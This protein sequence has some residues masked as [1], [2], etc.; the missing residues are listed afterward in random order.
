M[1]KVTIVTCAIVL[2]SLMCWNTF[3]ALPIDHSP[4]WANIIRMASVIVFDGQDGNASATVYAKSG[5]TRVEGTLTVYKAS[6]GIW[7]YVDSASETTTTNT[8]V[9]L[10]VDFDAVSGG[11]YKSV[12]EVKVT[13]NGIEESETKY[14][15][16]TCP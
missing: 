12:F 14:S 8:Y 7:E 2:A 4:Q 15:Y 1:K 16:K 9:S 3:G 13:R 11:Y 5:A 10:S 6:G